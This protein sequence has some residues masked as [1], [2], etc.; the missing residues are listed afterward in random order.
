MKIPFINRYLT[1]GKPNTAKR[2]GD[3][4]INNPAHWDKVLGRV[5]FDA[6]AG[7]AVTP[8]AAM[9]ASA[10]YA[11]IRVLAFTLGQLPL[12]TYRR[13]ARGKERAYDHPVYKLLHIQPNPEIDSFHWRATKMAHVCLYGNAYSEIEYNAAGQPI[14]LWL[15]PAWRCQP[16]RVNTAR[17]K[18]VLVYEVQLPDGGRKLLLQRNVLHIKGLG[19]DGML[20]LSVIQQ[21]AQSIGVSLAAQDFAARFFGQGMNVGGVLEHPGALSDNAY[22][23]LQ[24]SFEEKYVGLNKAH[25][26]ML[27][28]EGLKF[29]KIGINPEEAQFLESR[30]FQIV[31]IARMFGVPPHKI[32]E[33]TRATFSNIE[34]QAIEFVTDTM[35]PWFVNWEQQINI[36]LLGGGDTYFAEFLVEGL[37]RGDSISRGQFY[38]QMFQMAA[39]SPNDIREREN[40]NP[41][42]HGDVYFYPLNLTPI[43]AN[44]QENPPAQPE[45]RQL[46]RSLTEAR[47]RVTKSYGKVFEDAGAKIVAREVKNLRRE[48]KKH[49]GERALDTARKYLDDYYRDFQPFI[50]STIQPAALALGQAILPLAQQQINSKNDVQLDTFIADY[51]KAFAYRY[52]KSSRGQIEELLDEEDLDW[53]D[54]DARLD[55]WETKRPGKVARRETVQ[56]AN[57]VAQVVFASAGIAMLVWRNMGADVCPYCQEMDGARV[58]TGQD[59]LAHKSRLDAEGEGTMEIYRPASHP[60]LHDGCQC[61]LEP[62]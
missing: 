27:L 13:L 8:D 26:L 17:E 52:A 11:C 34:H 4:D 2:A 28:E 48:L 30:Q 25:R 9:R 41:V 21:G 57:A 5:Y 42:E 32:A 46:Q 12:V 47:F 20:G 22:K 39:L 31:D 33:L 55:E 51:D 40:M 14:A 36:K 61:Q 18:N 24:T 49:I 53:A 6:G 45:A 62:G 56:V 38:N 50:A 43:M 15:I 23:R 44:G 3:L 1:I 10:V 60:P 19:T 29:N 58:S 59:F 7:V 37:L 54:I 16:M 35:M